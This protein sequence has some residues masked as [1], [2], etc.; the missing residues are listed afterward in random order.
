MDITT[1]LMSKNYIQETV[2]G[3]GAI[4]GKSAYE[5]ACEHGFLGTEEQWLDS[6]SPKVTINNNGNL[7]INGVDTNVTAAANI[8]PIPTDRINEIIRGEI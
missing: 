6:L 3:A 1:Y 2:E 7:V 5:I 8:A 4:K